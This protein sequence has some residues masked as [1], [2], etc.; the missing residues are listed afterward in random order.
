KE[1]NVSL[2]HL[3]QILQCT[4]PRCKRLLLT[5]KGVQIQRKTCLRRIDFGSDG[6]RHQPR[7]AATSSCR[8]SNVL[9][10]SDAVRHRE[11]LHCRREFG[12]PKHLSGL[13]VDR[14]EHLVAIANERNTSSRRQHGCQERGSLLK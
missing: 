14:L 5:R 1:G 7:A 8:H 13:Y 2:R 4:A 12:F 9:F 10:T 11:S 3:R 6:I